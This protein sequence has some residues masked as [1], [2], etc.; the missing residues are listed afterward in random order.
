MLFYCY[1]IVINFPT[2]T[3]EKDALFFCLRAWGFLPEKYTFGNM[4]LTMDACFGKGDLKEGLPQGEYENCT[5]TEC[6]FSRYDFSG[7]VFADCRFAGCDLSLARLTGTALREVHFKA[8]KMLGLHF[9]D[10]NPLGLEAGFEACVM[11]NCTFYEVKMPKTVFRDTRL[12][13]AD[14]TAADLTGATFAGCDFLGATFDRTILEKADLRTSVHH[15][16]DPARNRIRKARF[17][18]S[19]LPGLL[20]A[21]DITVDP[22]T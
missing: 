13:E 10:C 2:T 19:Q 6:D 18:L 11:D 5:F 14:F 9:E 17:S 16:I 7:Y 1:V 15:S 3:A 22:A 12:R 21:W 20:E 8:C 4:K